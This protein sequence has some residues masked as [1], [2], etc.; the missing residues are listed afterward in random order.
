MSVNINVLKAVNSHL[1]DR[2]K[3]NDRDYSYFHASSWE[4]CHRKVAYSYYESKGAINIDESALKL[5]SQLERIFD[6]GHY[7]H[8]RWRDYLMGTAV[9]ALLGRWTCIN[10]SAHPEPKLFGTETKFGC[11]KPS[12]CECG[13]TKFQYAEV[14]F[15]DDETWW[16]GHVDAIIDITKWPYKKLGEYKDIAALPDDERYFLIDFKTMNPFEFKGLEKPKTE[17]KTQ[18]QVY[19]YL[20]GLKFGKF[21]YENKANQA[22]KEF[23]VLRDDAMIAVKREEAIRLRYQVTNTNSQGQHVL[24]PRG[25]DSRGHKKCLECKY[26]GH[27]WNGVK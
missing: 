9:D 4:D 2:A 6:N 27:C 25:Y 19:L 3:A 17:H 13:S 24:P 21:V 8:D 22:V 20:S 5:N 26:R 10:W 18:M 7:T 12:K 23:L 11:T 14:G 16:G 15:R 1:L